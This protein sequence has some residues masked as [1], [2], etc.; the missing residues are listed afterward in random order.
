MKTYLTQMFH[1]VH[2]QTQKP[3]A[4]EIKLN[5]PSSPLTLNNKTGAGQMFNEPSKLKS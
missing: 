5:Q 2:N 4:Q 3:G 1:T